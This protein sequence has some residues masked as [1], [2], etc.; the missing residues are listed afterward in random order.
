MLFAV[1]SCG[2]WHPP[3]AALPPLLYP[4]GFWAAVPSS[5]CVVLVMLSVMLCSRAELCV[6]RIWPCI[7]QMQEIVLAYLCCG[8]DLGMGL[9]DI[10]DEG[11]KPLT[12]PWDVAGGDWPP[13]A[14]QI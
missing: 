5:G 12:W 14:A 1:M 9:L 13:L 11:P 2:L 10:V 3:V 6:C 8:L 4:L 7:V